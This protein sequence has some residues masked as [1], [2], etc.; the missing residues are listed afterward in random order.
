MGALICE[1]FELFEI[2]IIPMDNVK[3]DCLYVKLCSNYKYKLTIWYANKKLK[4]K[5]I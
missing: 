3:I 1:F 2:I 5:I 4:Q